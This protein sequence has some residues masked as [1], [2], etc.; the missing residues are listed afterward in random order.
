MANASF[1]GIGAGHAR[2]GASG[3]RLAIYKACWFNLCTDA[4]LLS[5][6][7]VA[8]KDGVDIISI[9]IG[10]DPPQ[11][12]FFQDAI[13]I[14][15]FH[16]FMNQILVSASAGNSGLPGT[17]CNTAPWMLTVAASSIDQRFNVNVAL[18]NSKVLKVNLEISC[19]AMDLCTSRSIDE[20]E[21]IRQGTS[22]NPAGLKGS[23]ALV[24]ANAAA[25]PGVSSANAW[26]YH[27]FFYFGS[28]ST[29]YNC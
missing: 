19:T 1:L 11:P 6:L 9:S 27:E 5:A 7:D 14:G 22:L 24:L 3:A 15:S 28:I 18:G 10:P 12:S 8:S 23:H 21:V 25:A 16:A 26:Y 13:S 29:I 20:L 2:G 17:A 4:D